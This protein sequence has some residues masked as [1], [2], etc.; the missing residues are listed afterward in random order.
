MNSTELC[1]RSQIFLL[2][3]YPLH[4]KNVLIFLEFSFYKMNV[5]TLL[6]GFSDLL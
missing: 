3:V 2:V 6:A 5:R 4:E 1:L